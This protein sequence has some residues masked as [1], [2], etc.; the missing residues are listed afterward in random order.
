MDQDIAQIARL[1]LAEIQYKDGYKAKYILHLLNELEYTRSYLDALY[2]E[3][4]S[5]LKETH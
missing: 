5:V 4:K 3:I 1:A 2:K